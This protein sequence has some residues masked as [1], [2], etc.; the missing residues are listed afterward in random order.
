MSSKELCRA[1]MLAAVVTIF[2]FPSF[3][4]GGGGGGNP[5][6][7]EPRSVNAPG[8]TVVATFG[9]RSGFT[10][11]LLFK[12]IGDRTGTDFGVVKVTSVTKIAGTGDLSVV[13][14]GRVRL[15]NDRAYDVFIFDFTAV[16]P[17]GTG[18]PDAGK[19]VTGRATI[20]INPEQA[21]VLPLSVVDITQ[22]GNIELRAQAQNSRAKSLAIVDKANAI[23][24][25]TKLFVDVPEVAW[26][27]TNGVDLNNLGNGRVI[28][29]GAAG[30]IQTAL[31]TATYPA[32]AEQKTV[33][34]NVIPHPTVGVS[35]PLEGAT[36]SGQVTVTFVATNATKV[37][38]QLGGGAETDVTG[39]TSFSFD[40][41]T[42]PDGPLTITM[43][44]TGKLETVSMTRNVTVNNAP[45][46]LKEGHWELDP[47]GTLYTDSD[48][49]KRPNWT[50]GKT[51]NGR[52]YAW[53]P[54]TVTFMNADGSGITR[55]NTFASSAPSALMDDR[56]QLALPDQD[57][58][59]VRIFDLNGIL[60]RDLSNLGA[61]WGT[62]YMN[63]KL[64]TA[65][66]VGI[67]EWN[68]V[69]WSSH[70]IVGGA[71]SLI[72]GDGQRIF[73][74]RD[75]DSHV[76]VMD[77]AGTVVRDLGDHGNVQDIIISSGSN[78]VAISVSSGSTKGAGLWQYKLN[79]DFIR[80]D[81]FGAMTIRGLDRD[82]TDDNVMWGGTGALDSNGRPFL[83][84]FRF[85]AD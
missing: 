58:K 79:G 50:G 74:S 45:V 82:W 18:D 65:S 78:N 4:C 12:W 14:E 2:L 29:T 51:S 66:D 71:Y 48:G 21:R 49:I 15:I 85:V 8:N 73:T 75:S 1:A 27:A 6:P 52:M 60:L 16:H 62:D 26:T 23:T 35:A 31:V 67:R 22:D 47:A 11:D 56:G 68:P 76:V 72:S 40:S 84:R 32:T 63:G 20:H 70:P 28:V 55:T 54:T 69:D 39:Q 83:P 34:V 64:L 81:S 3:G 19:T 25:K 7:N 44:A 10:N 37:T 13:G 53:N 33:T 38:Y 36:V 43:R 46:V 5:P 61:V 59:R 80:H 30:F 42:F 41:K 17:S 24:N 9:S 77:Y 57:A